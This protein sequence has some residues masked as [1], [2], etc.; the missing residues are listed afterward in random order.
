MDL[1][2]KIADKTDE[3]CEKHSYE[4][5]G[6]MFGIYVIGLLPELRDLMLSELQDPII[7]KDF[8]SFYT[9]GDMVRISYGGFFGGLLGGTLFKGLFKDIFDY[10]FPD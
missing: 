6:A 4:I 7:N 1:K 5:F 9:I 3:F 10:E 2:N 8:S